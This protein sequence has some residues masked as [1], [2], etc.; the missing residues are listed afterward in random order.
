MKEQMPKNVYQL[1]SAVSAEIAKTGIGKN[2]TNT[3]QRYQFRGIDDLY[4]A[5]GP[6]LAKHGLLMLPEIVNKR[7]EDRQSKDK[8]MIY[9]YVTMQYT[10]VS[11][12]DGSKHTITVCGEAS[13][14][15][16]KA[17][18][19]AMSMAYKYACIQSFSIPIVGK[20][21]SEFESNEIEKSAVIN[22][23]ES[24]EIK[25]LLEKTGSDVNKF[26]QYFNA[27][28]VDEMTKKQ[29]TS[30]KNILGK[31][32]VINNNAEAGNE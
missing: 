8:T 27:P 2:Q 9:A 7:Y 24:K 15:S 28:N 10:F 29:Y 5:I 12:N 22:E 20:E 18:N 13:D 30:A 23:Q 19:K 6:I 11:A 17:S 4:N 32:P 26:L 16:D 31:K 3:H 21:D 1:I 25:D 14:T